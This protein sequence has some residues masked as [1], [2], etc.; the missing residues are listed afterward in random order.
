[1][2]SDRA[3]D[4]ALARFQLH[5]DLDLEARY[6]RDTN[7]FVQSPDSTG[8]EFEVLAAY[9]LGKFTFRAGALL[10]RRLK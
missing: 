7:E 2:L 3:F 10:Q 9:R 5:R 8:R 1:M 4:Q 6:T